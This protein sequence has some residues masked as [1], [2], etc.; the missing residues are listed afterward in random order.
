MKC[1]IY[2]IINKINNKYYIG[3]SNNICEGSGNRWWRHIYQLNKNKHKNL[4]LQNAWNKYGPNSFM[5]EIIEECTED[6]LLTKEQFYLNLCKLNP[7]LNYNI[8][9]D[10]SA[11]MK[12]RNHTEETKDK[13][14]ELKIGNSWNK[15]KKQSTEHIQNRSKSLKGRLS[16]MKNK[17]QSVEHIQKVA[18]AHLKDYIFISPDGIITN[19]HG[20]TSWCKQNNLSVSGM[21]LVNNNLRPHHKGWKKYIY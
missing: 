8:S 14:R 19:V 6:Q 7:K 1:G 12:G 4:H 21:S 5:F 10:A 2:K 16:P 15:G 17:K 18:N 13:M 20:L 11:P 3:S 9:Y